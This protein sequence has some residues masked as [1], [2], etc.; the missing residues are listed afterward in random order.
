MARTTAAAAEARAYGPGGQ[1]ARRRASIRIVC[2]G[3]STAVSGDPRSVASAQAMTQLEGVPTMA[4][5]KS[6]ADA[7]SSMAV[8]A[9]AIDCAA[10]DADPM[11]RADGTPSSR[12]ALKIRPRFGLSAVLIRQHDHRRAG[13]GGLRRAR[14]ARVKSVDG[15]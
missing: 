14:D 4:T 5:D 11:R 8:S 7:S 1:R 3:D 13:L 15:A 2:G 6:V 9:H 12:A 10:P